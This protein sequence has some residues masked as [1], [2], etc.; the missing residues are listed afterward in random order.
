MAAHPSPDVELMA[1]CAEYHDAVALLQEWDARQADPPKGSPECLAEE[2]Y[3]GVLCDREQ[4]AVIKAGK[5]SAQS[6]PGLLA[7]GRMLDHVMTW[8]MRDIVVDEGSPQIELA[9]SF[10]RD[11]QNILGGRP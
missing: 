11:V 1:V 9:L 3:G 4:Q 7:K 5:L 10:A 6:L 2:E 8:G